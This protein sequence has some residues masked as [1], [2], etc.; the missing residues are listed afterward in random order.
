MDY[1]KH[2]STYMKAI[3]GTLLAFLGAVQATLEALPDGASWGDVSTLGWVIIAG[4]TVATFGAIF[5]VQNA[6]HPE[7]SVTEPES[8]PIPLPPQNL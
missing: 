1:L 8:P 6:D 3:I 5:G 4:I 2:P 7:A